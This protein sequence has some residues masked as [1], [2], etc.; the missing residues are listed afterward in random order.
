[1]VPRSISAICWPW[2]KMTEGCKV[3]MG[4]LR[5]ELNFGAVLLG[6]AS[7]R[8]DEL[9]IRTELVDVQN[10]WLICGE[11]IRRNIEICAQV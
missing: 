9:A 2:K 6:R 11:Q 3:R 5:E 7:K 4:L 1:M 8:G 10:G